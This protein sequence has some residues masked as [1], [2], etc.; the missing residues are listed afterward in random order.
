MVAV[1]VVTAI[2]MLLLLYHMRSVV[3]VVAVIV[4]V[5]PQAIGSISSAPAGSIDAAVAHALSAL[6]G[7]L[8]EMTRSGAISAA[9]A[10]A[11]VQGAIDGAHGAAEKEVAAAREALRERVRKA[12]KGGEVSDLSAII[13]L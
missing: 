2:A 11:I 7:D 8:A 3:A 1:V 13:S 5:A 4:V 6:D 10:E 9:D 12:T